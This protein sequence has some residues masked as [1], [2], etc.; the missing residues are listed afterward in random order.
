MGASEPFKGI[1]A[2]VQTAQSGSFAAASAALGL[3]QSAVSKSVARLEDRLGIRL[4]HRTTR[5]L[6]LTDEGRLYLES[7]R[8]ALE[9][10]SEAEVVLSSRKDLPSG[11]VRINLP[12]LY[13]KKCIAPVL[14]ELAKTYPQ[15]HFE[16]SFENR[17]VNL[18]EEGYDLAIRIGDLSDSSDLI[19]KRLG[20]QDVIICASPSYL[21]KYGTPLALVNL[22]DHLCITQFRSG[23]KEPWYFLNEQG[24][25]V[26]QDI[27]SNHSFT[28]FDMIVDAALAGL[29]LVQV[30]RWLIEDELLSGKLIEVLPKIKS[31]SMPIH[32]LWPG[33]RIMASRV[34]V[35]IDAMTAMAKLKAI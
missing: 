16:I 4:F 15:L 17:I 8:R 5:S 29:G 7:C 6:S 3:S 34:R 1:N 26:Q 21:A 31:P 2:F 28:A 25:K 24:E 12:D 14:I 23:R 11:R 32:L 33:G 9:V 18:I 35:T 10:L 13:G 20:N 27:Q 19:S 30:P 22:L